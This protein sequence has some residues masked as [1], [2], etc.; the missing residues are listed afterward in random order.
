MKLQLLIPQYNETDEIIKPMLDSLLVQQNVDFNEFGV[1]IVNDGSDIFLSEELLKSYPYQIDYYK[2]PHRGV[3]A[4]RNT[5][6]DYASA[7]YVMFCDADDMFC[8][9]CGLWLIFRE[10]S[11]GFD[12]LSSKFIEEG[13]KPN[14]EIIYIHRENDNTFVHGKIHRRKYLIDNDIRWN[15][16]LTIHEDSYFNAQCSALAKT[17]KYLNEAFYLWRYRADS[18]CR[19]D[20]KYILK[21]LPCLVDSIDGLIDKLDKSNKHDLAVYYTVFLLMDVFYTINK[22]EWRDSTNVEYL[23]KI[24]QRSFEFFNKHRAKWKE[25]SMKTALEISNRQRTKAI[26]EGMMLENISITEWLQK[27]D[28][29]YLKRQ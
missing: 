7:D 25:C 16:E 6:L 5:C 11:F 20:P 9:V 12:T 3:S 17:P 19:H 1:I 29:Y 8:S 23:N 27:L 15:P 28:M 14:G 22:P 10:I 24:E 21:T 2:A 4:T 18:V 13:H 26:N